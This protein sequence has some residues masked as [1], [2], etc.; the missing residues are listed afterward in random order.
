MIDV[1]AV[2]MLR[3]AHDQ[4][5]FEQGDHKDEID[6]AYSMGADAI[7]RLGAMQPSVSN[8]G[9]YPD[10]LYIPHTALE[11]WHRKWPALPAFDPV[12]AQGESYEVYVIQSS[13]NK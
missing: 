7:E 3:Q 8:T 2:H 1:I 5:C 4:L 9:P 11:Q 13:K 12:E 6:T 10:R